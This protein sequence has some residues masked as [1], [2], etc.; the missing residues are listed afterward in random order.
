MTDASWYQDAVIYELRIRSFFDSNDDG[1][2]DIRGLTQ[3]LDYLK[4]LGVT[5]IWTLPFYPSP[6]RDDG[7][8]IA[9]YFN[10]H[11]AIGEIGDFREMLREAHARGLQVIT[12]L[13]LNH[14][15]DQHP[16]FERARRAPAGSPERDFYVWTDDPSKWSQARIIFQDFE[17]SNWCWDPVAGAY[18]WHRFFSHQPDLNFENAEVQRAML[19]VVDFWLEMGVDGLRLDAVPYLYEREGTTCENLPETHAFL[20]K[21]RAHIDAKFPNRML[22]AEANQWPEDAV[23]YLGKGDECHM[24]FHFPL[25][26]RLFMALRME[27]SYPIIDILEQTPAIPENCQWALFLRN[28]D[29]LTLEMV[30]EEE[31]DYMIKR[32]AADHQMRIN[33]GIR[34]R[35]APL[36]EN[37][38]R[39]I[40]LM[41]VLLLSLPGTPVLYYGDEIGMGDNPY[42]GDRN[43]VRTPMQ[44]SPDRN[45]GFS[46]ANPQRLILPPIVDPE[47]SYETV[48]VEVQQRNSSSLLWWMKRL[49]G[50]RKAS[51]ALQ[52]GTLEMLAP[53]NRKVLAFLRR[54]EGEVMLVV[55]NLSR[56]AQ[57]VELDLAEFRGSAP[58]EVFGN[59]EFPPIDGSLYRL[60]LGS[61]DALWLSLT[62][63]IAQRTSVTTSKPNHQPL[64]HAGEPAE[65]LAAGSALEAVLSNYLPSQRWFRSKQVLT[66]RVQILA[67]LKLSENT[68]LTYAAVAT[69]GDEP[70]TYVL[71]IELTPGKA[72]PEGALVGLLRDGDATPGAWLRDA[73]YSAETALAL[74]ALCFDSR[75]V[76]SAS[77]A[78]SGKLTGVLPGAEAAL[79]ARPLRTEQTNTSYV[80]GDKYIG[81]LVRTV[82]PGG[83]IEVQVLEALQRQEARANVPQLVGLVS[84]KV[85]AETALLMTLQSYVPNEGDA[86]QLTLDHVQRYYERVLTERLKPVPPSASLL[87]SEPDEDESRSTPHEYMVLARLLGTRTAELHAA[88]FTAFRGEHAPRPYTSLTSRGFYQSVRNLTGKAADALKAARLPEETQTLA[89]DL[90]DR[91][92]DLRKRLDRAL[93]EPLAGQTMRIHGDYHL[94]QVLYTGRD[95]YIIDFEG[96]PARSLRER[97]RLRSPMADVAGMLRSFHYA[98]LGAL[99]YPLPGAHV[100]AEDRPLLMP[101]AK[102]FY[103]CSAR[104]FLGGYF[105]AL[106][107]ID[108]LPTSSSQRSLLL[109][110]HLLEKALYELVYEL[111]NRP[112]WVELP[113]RGVLDLLGG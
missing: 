82:E 99:L 7:Y 18:Y 83:S 13:V 43:G 56:F 64:M 14:T 25:M 77:I 111:Q 57:W 23:A 106:G 54:H 19:E 6:L 104:A 31:R 76:R 60:T 101:W 68:W 53:E 26:P 15:S 10:V 63:S 65:L 73:S 37:D 55:I 109:E 95:F 40:E 75:E 84:T 81:K 72:Q 102:H 16:W 35:L 69:G 41:N 87:E 91:W 52:R 51:P 47:Y 22:L 97:A 21:L 89:N 8:D 32:Y 79:A 9:D 33:L 45:G 108:I 110:M 80:F 1:I 34:R 30:T 85:G 103:E 38:R 46:R 98:A 112:S 100:R 50:A 5:A 86:W 29:E 12:E 61:H 48:N 28:H 39:R 59:G 49:I 94:G 113:L 17:S 107:G 70:E 3:K 42:L 88:M 90:R 20:R 71:P 24:A 4:D 67:S 44:W 92:N 11:P 96:E 93:V 58:V 2:G 105:A 66:P 36:L 27:D 62:R 74:Q 78:V